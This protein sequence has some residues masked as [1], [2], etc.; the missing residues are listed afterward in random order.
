[1]QT[2]QIIVYFNVK[3]TAVFAKA[4]ICTPVLSHME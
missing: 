4:H 2:K 1:M 3:P